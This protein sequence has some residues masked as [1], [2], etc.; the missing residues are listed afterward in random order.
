MTYDPPKK[1][2]KK[3]VV[4]RLLDYS[5]D[6]KEIPSTIKTS[7]VSNLSFDEIVDELQHDWVVWAVSFEYEGMA[8]IGSLQAGS[9]DPEGF[10]H[11]EIEDCEVE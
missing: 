11:D 9:F 8:C 2:K 3:L 1:K 6:M 10:K 4:R 5:L 7:Q